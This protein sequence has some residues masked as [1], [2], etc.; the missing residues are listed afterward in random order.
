[1][2]IIILL[3]SLLLPISVSSDSTPFT[4]NQIRNLNLARE[5]SIEV[6]LFPEH[7]LG[8]IILQES[9][10]GWSSVYRKGSLDGPHVGIAQV[11]LAAAKQVLNR[12]II[13]KYSNAELKHKL[14][15]DDEFNLRI[16]ANYLLYLQEL[17]FKDPALMALAYN[18]GP[19]AAK[20]KKTSPYSKSIKRHLTNLY[21]S[22]NF[23]ISNRI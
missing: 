7:L 9:G 5:I 13:K 17:G 3:I 12:I 20:N 10:A 22:E 11:G 21:E 19:G 16:A 15:N 23:Y 8:A 2:K 1:M 14:A 18:M 4:E 6:G